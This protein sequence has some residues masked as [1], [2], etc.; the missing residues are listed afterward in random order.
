MGNVVSR[1]GNTYIPEK[2]RERNKKKKCRDPKITQRRTNHRSLGALLDGQLTASSLKN[3]PFRILIPA[4]EHK[5]GGSNLNATAAIMGKCSLMAE[6]TSL[7]S[8]TC[9]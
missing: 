4:A 7:G 8:P 9:R 2:K 3:H 6:G 5:V 1:T